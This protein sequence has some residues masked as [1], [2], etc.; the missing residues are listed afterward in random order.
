MK[1]KYSDQVYL[2]SVLTFQ[3]DTET[4]FL[5]DDLPDLEPSEAYLPKHVIFQPGDC[6][7]MPVPTSGDPS[8]Q[9]FATQCNW[10]LAGRDYVGAS[11]DGMIKKAGLMALSLRSNGNMGTI[12][13][14]AGTPIKSSISMSYQMGGILDWVDL[15]K[16]GNYGRLCQFPTR[17]LCVGMEMYYLEYTVKAFFRIVYDI[18]V[19]TTPEQI[20]MFSKVC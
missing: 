9:D 6:V 2:S 16:A 3:K 19:L 12:L 14:T 20:D 4:Y 17:T 11:D 15:T 7:A 8:A 13:D 1:I 10:C 18:V 5:L